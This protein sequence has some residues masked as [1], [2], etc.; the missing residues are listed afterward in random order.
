MAAACAR[1]VATGTMGRQLLVV[2]NQ[3]MTKTCEWIITFRYSSYLSDILSDI[4]SGITT[5]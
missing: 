5:F 1:F 4:T 2:S 3:G